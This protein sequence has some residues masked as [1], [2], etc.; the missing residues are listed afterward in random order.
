[1]SIGWSSGRSHE[2]SG[3][4]IA[5]RFGSVEIVPMCSEAAQKRLPLNWMVRSKGVEPPYGYGYRH[6]KHA[7]LPI[8]SRPR[9]LNCST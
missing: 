3:R 1:M 5:V 6:L 7:R 2:D 9:T 8:P 4:M